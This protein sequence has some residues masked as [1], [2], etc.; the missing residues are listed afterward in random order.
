MDYWVSDY[1]T[2]ALGADKWFQHDEGLQRIHFT[3]YNY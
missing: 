3:K 2:A 1:H